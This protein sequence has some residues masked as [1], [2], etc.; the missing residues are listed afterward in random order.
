MDDAVA[1]ALIDA[2]RAA[3]R[4][5]ILPR[6]RDLSPTDIR[7]KTGPEDLVTVA[8]R[9]AEAALATSIDRILPDAAIVGEEAAS[10]DP[11]VIDA[12]AG[13]GPVAVIDPI[14]GT[15]NFARGLAT[16]GVILAVQEAG[17]TVFGLLYDPVLDDWMVA[18]P[19]RGAV[20]GRPGIAPR[21]LAVAPPR[22]PEEEVG[23][24]SLG[25]FDG[26][27]GAAPAA[28]V[29]RLERVHTL[30]CSCHE[31]RM[32]ASGHA[33]WQF[34]PASKPWDHLAGRL[35]F[36]EAGGAIGSLNGAPYDPTDPTTALISAS[37]AARRDE[38]AAR[39]GKYLADRADPVADR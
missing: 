11:T 9:A 25:L 31:Y 34:V 15:W 1:A 10:E 29:P 23:Y 19:G 3:A 27:G 26:P 6:F 38:L 20:Y 21:P 14:D 39:F 33:D 32:L 18:R 30:H 17:E 12:L 24:M 36:A 37:S 4:A 7:T 13:D 2:V 35:V 16:F 22:P 28:L 8:D 5:E